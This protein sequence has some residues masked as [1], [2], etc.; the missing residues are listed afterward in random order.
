MTQSPIPKLTIVIQPQAL[1]NRVFLKT[2]PFLTGGL[3]IL[4]ENGV[5][6]TNNYTSTFTISTASGSASLATG[7]TISQH[8]ITSD[9]WFANDM[10]GQPSVSAT[11]GPYAQYNA[12]TQLPYTNQTTIGPQNMR[13]N[14]IGDLLVQNSPASPTGP[15][16]NVSYA[17]GNSTL[18]SV[19]DAGF[20]GK[21][22]YLDN[23]RTGSTFV[24]QQAATT[25]VSYFST[26]PQFL[27][28]FNT[29]SGIL[30]ANEFGT[31]WPLFF[32]NE[33][34]PAYDA[35]NRLTYDVAYTGTPQIAGSTL[36]PASDFIFT[37]VYN[38]Y[39][40]NLALATLLNDING[41]TLPTTN[42]MILW[43]SMV[44]DLIMLRRFGVLIVMN[45]LIPSIGLII[46]L[47]RL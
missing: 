7:S 38:Q 21:A 44:G 2:I 22:V 20:L 6:Y 30:T 9:V 12:L 8:G 36:L 18:I 25:A 43:V 26:F 46:I 14:P 35:V 5:N 42:Q 34:N 31:S 16:V 41:I 11:A 40:L 19:L 32:P 15:K 45:M 13:R 37:P 17:V 24:D 29:N 27:A 28:D 33:N 1:S 47:R 10:P 3:K 4:L 23:V 39:L